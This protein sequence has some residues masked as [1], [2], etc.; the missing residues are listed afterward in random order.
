MKIIVPHTTGRLNRWVQD[1]LCRVGAQ[2]KVTDGDHSYVDLM[3]EL[4]NEG[5]TFV[6]NEGDKLP[7]PG[8]VQELHDCP[9]LWC[10]HSYRRFVSPTRQGVG[11]YYGFGC[12][13]FH[14]DLIRLI[15]DV[16]REMKNRHH[17]NIDSY[18]EGYT[19]PRSLRVHHHR[20]AIHHLHDYDLPRGKI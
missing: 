19:W 12:V 9:M 8:A 17:T 4:W 6:I 14:A 1:E 3:E 11:D 16:W 15:P 20:P 7:W 18:F 10:A 2:F 5:E 13:K